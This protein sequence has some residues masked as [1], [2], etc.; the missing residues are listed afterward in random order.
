VSGNSFERYFGVASTVTVK[1]VLLGFFKSPE[2]A[3][4]S[5]V[6]PEFRTITMSYGVP[7]PLGQL[8]GRLDHDCDGLGRS[9]SHTT[10]IK[11]NTGKLVSADAEWGLAIPCSM[12]YELADLPSDANIACLD[13]AAAAASGRRS[14]R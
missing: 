6:N 7:L 1:D 12:A 3:R 9:G 4:V 8:G 10:T 2:A 13:F 5:I 14:T 11:G